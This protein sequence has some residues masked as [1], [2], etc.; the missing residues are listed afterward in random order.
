[1]L[2]RWSEE[3]HAYIVA[4]PEFDNARTHGFTYEEAAQ[5][6]RELIESF[7]MWYQ[8][9][10][11]PLPNPRLFIYPGE[12]PTQGRLTLSG[13]DEDDALPYQEHDVALAI[14]EKVGR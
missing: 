8:Q 13:N 5:M 12:A 1:M 10:G 6:G 2:I 7:V 14:E 3:D 9:D 4:L 11:K